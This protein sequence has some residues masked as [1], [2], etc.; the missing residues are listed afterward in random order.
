MQVLANLQLVL[1]YTN[2]PVYGIV[3]GEFLTRNAEKL[4]FELKCIL[5]QCT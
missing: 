3:K 5:D 1:K 2:S 4:H